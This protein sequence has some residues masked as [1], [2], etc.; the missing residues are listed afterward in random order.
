MSIV[1]RLRSLLGDDQVITDPVSMSTYSTDWTKTWSSSP[2]AVV[3]PRNSTE[4]GIV[5]SEAQKH[6]IA[7][8]P[9]GG[10]T[11]LVGGSVGNDSFQ[12]IIV[13]TRLLRDPIEFD[14][15]TNQLTVSAGWMLSEVQKFAETKGLEYPVDIA[16]RD[17]A[18]IGGTIATNA[19]GIHVIAHG[20]TRAQVVGVEIVVP[21]GRVL[22]DI[23]PI[24]QGFVH[25]LC[26]DVVGSEGTLGII[27]KAQLQLQQPRTAQWTAIVPTDSLD[28]AV[29]LSLKLGSDVLASEI[30]QTQTALHVAQHAGKQVITAEYSWLVLLESDGPLIHLPDDSLVAFSAHDRRELWSYR[31][32]H[33]EYIATK[34]NVLK[35]DARVPISALE[36]FV[37]EVRQIAT[38]T[39]GN[40]EDFVVFGHLLDGNLH[41][42]ISNT[43]DPAELQDEI[44]ALIISHNGSIRAEHGIGQAKS[45][46]VDQGFTSA[47]LVERVKRRDRFDPNRIMNP[48]IG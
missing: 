28:Q 15:A 12:H 17:S 6:A 24:A 11:G 20:M 43:G 34:K 48:S 7:V 33:T 40:A 45:R 23:S 29:K 5:L 31:E 4:V 22:H 30:M 26:D 9:Q 36:T 35:F 16:A 44:A 38:H 39:T 13:S 19:G 21:D 37:S 18:T 46:Y 2:L 3:R 42:A 41:L 27:T 32:R 8:I 47:E 1:E 14:A 10:N 25:G